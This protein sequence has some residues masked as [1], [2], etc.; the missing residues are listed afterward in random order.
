MD[1]FLIAE[2]SSFF[3]P[4]TIWS[5][6]RVIIGLGFVIFVHELGHFLVA[7]M[8][9][10]K[11]EKFYV[12]FDFFDIKIGDTVLIP[13]AL[14]KWQWG[15][16][17]YGIGVI[18]LGGYVKMLGQDDNPGQIEAENERSG[19]H[20]QSEVGGPIDRDKLDPRSYQ[21]K[22]V[23]QRMAIIS[24]GVIFNIIFA[25]FLAAIA[26][27]SGVSYQ[28]AVASIAMPGSPAWVNNMDGATFVRIGD[29]RFD[30]GYAPWI[31]VVQEI[32][33][34]FDGQPL[35][36]EFIPPG[37]SES[38]TISVMP[39]K[40][41]MRESE[42]AGLGLSGEQSTRLASS[43]AI[44]DE[45]S[46]E[47]ANPPFES[48]DQVIA[49]DGSPVTRLID[50]RRSLSGIFDKEATFTVERKESKDKDA[51]VQ[52]LDI[53]VPPNPRMELGFGLEIGPIKGIRH[54]SP[55]EKAGA[56]I[57]DRLLAING[58]PIA[59]PT[60]I[61]QHLIRL[62]RDGTKSAVVSVKRM[63]ESGDSETLELTMEMVMPITFGTKGYN[64]MAID[65]L[66]IAAHLE[67]V[68]LSVV[69][70]SA[71]EKN[72][73][74]VG[75]VITTVDIDLPEDK[76]K[77]ERFK[78]LKT[79]LKIGSGDEIK[80]S[81]TRIAEV[82]NSVDDLPAGVTYKLSL[83][84]DGKENTIVNV[85]SSQ[86]SE[87]FRP[88]RGIALMPMEDF[89]A[90]ASWGESMA[91]GV[92]QV[93]T[94]LG[95]I[96]TFLK[97]LVTGAVSPTNLGG[98]GSIGIVATMEANQGTSRLLLF[99][100]ML[101]ANLAIVNLLPIP[102]LDGGH[103]V[104]LAYEGIMRRPVTEKVQIALSYVGLFFILGLMLFALVMDA[105]RIAGMFN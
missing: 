92:K 42:F 85:V 12:G 23:L 49:I 95:R 5:I 88:I 48:G 99:L 54:G 64:P 7:K 11:C 25:V 57:G 39:E 38:K 28:P 37:E 1:W 79:S 105:T 53:V 74:R 51:Q 50:M 21:A 87:Y 59:D 47:D 20:E 34:Q 13:R 29:K 52:T 102:V 27:R 4:T 60:T 56:K 9:G 66:G 83:R 45:Q 62:L 40:G 82:V 96:A 15:E 32:V 91:L 14:L 67:P 89:Y 84:R 80:S 55:A 35:E 2:G 10:V 70:G 73:L 6:A 65:T 77:D 76:K 41:L 86:S 103:L 18:P 8:C 3:D 75:D 101:S 19:M 81:Q 100:T 72:G 30:E 17:E 43:N 44:I 26:F 46:S 36:V 93:K 22:T 94:D 69:P 58:K 97:K 90:S 31:D 104:F 71:A 33:L 63:N 78:N 68:V 61:D 98:P 16:T 24:A